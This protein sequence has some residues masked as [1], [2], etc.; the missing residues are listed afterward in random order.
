MSHLISRAIILMLFANGCCMAQDAGN[1]PASMQCKV[2]PLLETFGATKWL[3]YSCSDGRSLVAVSA[4][5]SPAAPFYFMFQA[6]SNGHHLLGEGTGNKAETD[7]AYEELQQLS[8]REIL[9][10][11]DQTKGVNKH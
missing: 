9:A 11:I 10:L 5:G 1:T 4:P 8:E 2:G 7:K 6:T 3:V